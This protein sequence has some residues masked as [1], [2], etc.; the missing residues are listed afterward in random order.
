MDGSSI[1]SVVLTGSGD[2]YKGCGDL[3]RECV[4][5]DSSVSV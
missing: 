2:R 1:L 3:W 5:E 4:K